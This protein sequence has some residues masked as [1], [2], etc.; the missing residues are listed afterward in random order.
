MLCIIVLGFFTAHPTKGKILNF[1][2]GTSSQK[3]VLSNIDSENLDG[4]G[5][6]SMQI[7]ND[8]SF[9]TTWHNRGGITLRIPTGDS[10]TPR[11]TF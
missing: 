9:G 10:G 5:D 1:E 8:L 7:S 2:S 3:N 4:I 6:I 11:G